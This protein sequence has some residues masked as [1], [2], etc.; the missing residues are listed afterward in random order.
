ML[1][2]IHS[3]FKTI[4]AVRS[5]APAAAVEVRVLPDSAL[6]AI[7]GGAKQGPVGFW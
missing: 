7:G 2:T 4:L 1:S 6:R 3:W 5:T